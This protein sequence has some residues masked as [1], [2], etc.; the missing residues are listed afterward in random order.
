MVPSG[1]GAKERFTANLGT[2]AGFKVELVS[3]DCRRD[4]FYFVASVSDVVVS[5]WATVAAGLC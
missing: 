3:G 1:I 5:A 4:N 2:N